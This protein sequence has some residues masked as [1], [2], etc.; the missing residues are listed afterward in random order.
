MA[1]IICCQCRRIF[2]VLS[3]VP[4]CF[5]RQYVIYVLRQVRGCIE[6][7]CWIFSR[8]TYNSTTCLWSGSDCY[9][10]TAFCLTW[11]SLVVGATRRLSLVGIWSRCAKNI[12]EIRTFTCGWNEEV[13]SDIKLKQ[14]DER[15]LPL[16]NSW[17]KG[18]CAN[19]DCCSRNWVGYC[20]IWME[21]SWGCGMYYFG[22]LRMAVS[23]AAVGFILQSINKE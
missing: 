23:T 15:N 7:E 22:P 12:D 21:Q 10:F 17:R 2:K 14:V 11:C 13:N 9:W 8:V 18:E 1:R 19:N 5:S 4:L 6:C 3:Y 16:W 20:P